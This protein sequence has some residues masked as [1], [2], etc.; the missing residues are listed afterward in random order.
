MQVSFLIVIR[1]FSNVIRAGSDKVVHTCYGGEIRSC[2]QIE[3]S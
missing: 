2:I 1:F 3:W